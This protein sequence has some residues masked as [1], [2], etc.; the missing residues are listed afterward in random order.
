MLTEA[1]GYGN[2][3]WPCACNGYA[4]F[5]L[6]ETKIILPAQTTIGPVPRYFVVGSPCMKLII[7]F[8]V[9]I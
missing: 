2:A 1:H 3:T 9:S 6:D 5:P 8:V 7:S 4:A